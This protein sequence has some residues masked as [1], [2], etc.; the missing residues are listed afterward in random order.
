MD[1]GELVEDTLPL[2]AHEAADKR[3]RLRA[4]HRATRPVS[5]S[6]RDL[7]QVLVNLL[8][9]AIEASR[10]GAAVEVETDD[11]PSGGAVLCVR[12]H[13][14]GIREADLGRVF[15][16]FFTTRGVARHRSRPV[17]QLRAGAPLRR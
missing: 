12:D 5:I 10:D 2:V 16:P 4:R 15:D 8:S 1:L 14:E 17:R 6:P 7:Q 13:G 3:V 9:N 11:A